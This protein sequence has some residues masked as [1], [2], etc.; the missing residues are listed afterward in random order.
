[1]ANRI[2]Q[3]DLIEVNS[4]N[5]PNTPFLTNGFTN[6]LQTAVINPKRL[7]LIKATIPVSTVQLPDYG[8]IF[9]Y[10]RLDSAT[11]T[12]TTNNLKTVR[13]FPRNY[14]APSGL[15]YTP[16]LNRFFTGPSDL[17]AQL[18]VAAAASGDDGTRNPYWTAGDVVFTWNA[19]TQQITFRGTS[20]SYYYCPVGTLDANI[21][22][23]L[24]TNGITMA[25]AVGGG[26][27]NQPQIAGITL[28]PRLGYCLS[29]QTLNNQGTPG[30]PAYACLTNR[31][32]IG[33]SS[34]TTNA[35]PVD[36]FPNLIYT[37]NI[38]LYTSIVMNSGSAGNNANNKNLLAV[39]PASDVPNFGF[40]QFQ[41]NNNSVYATKLPETINRVDIQL[42]DD[43]NQPY[44]I[45]DNAYIS[46]L[47]GINYN[48]DSP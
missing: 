35:V 13:L 42:L 19:T 1:M 45:G 47:F 15:A 32:V 20:A 25:N 38:Y 23:G 27:T 2:L 16:T 33:G 43:A 40:I 22:A 17:V 29:G 9:W 14:V 5:D 46:V 18:N 24:A 8:L 7:T 31:P 6:D 39:I 34:A 4:F 11:Q 30:N 12:P 28:N 26:T 3:P 21:A 48:K 44:L 41:P 10:Y 37:G 36:N